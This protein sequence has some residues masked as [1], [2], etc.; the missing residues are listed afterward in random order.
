MQI[1]AFALKE[2]VLLD[3][4]NHIQIARR[5]AVGS[6]FAQ[7]GETNAGAVFH[8]R[9]DLGL[10][11][12]VAQ[13][14]PL[15]FAFG[16]R[17]GDDAAR[18]LTGGTSAGHTEEPLLIADLSTASAG[19]AGDGHLALGRAR[20]AA[21]FAG[22][23]A[24]DGNLG[25]LAEDCFLELQGD[26]LAQVRTALGAGAPASSS[27]EKIAE[28]E[29]VPENLAE[30]IEDGG[31]DA[32]RSSHSTDA[33]MAEPVI[34]G[35]LVRIRQNGVSLAALLEPVFRVGI[36]GVAVRVK[37]QSQLAVGALDLLLA[38]PAG[39]PEDFVVIAFYVASQNRIFAFR[40]M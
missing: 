3:M 12:S 9:R 22:F 39:N 18:T 31:I 34:G 15:A 37:L 7:A 13:N 40:R 26:V 38:G 30:I 19:A 35:S 36:V 1:G 11:G 6:G 4:Q 27:A 5:P 14:P 33:R 8:S 25:F 21:I 20:P 10:D 28:T 23:V 2:R 29:E 24:T 32:S 17:I 16:A